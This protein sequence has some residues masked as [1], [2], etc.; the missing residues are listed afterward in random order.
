[1]KNNKQYKLKFHPQF[2]L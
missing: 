2:L 1:V